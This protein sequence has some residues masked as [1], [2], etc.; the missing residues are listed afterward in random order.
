MMTGTRSWCTNPKIV[1]LSATQVIDCSL[2]YCTVSDTGAPSLGPKGFLTAFS[3]SHKTAEQLMNWLSGLLPFNRLFNLY[4][5]YSFLH[6][7]SCTGLMYNHWTLTTHTVPSKII[8]PPWRFSY[9]VA[10]QP[11]ISIW[12]SFHTQNG[13]NWWS[14]IQNRKVVSAYVFTHF[15]MKPLNKIWCNQ[16]PSEV[17]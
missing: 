17:T 3:P 4:L 8:H 12:I 6:W 9:F 14:E 2:C 13:P 16:L 10:L 7:L 5:Y 11:A 1:K 15:A